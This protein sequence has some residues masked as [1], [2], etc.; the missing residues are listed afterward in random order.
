MPWL[1]VTY[2]RSVPQSRRIGSKMA[3]D[4]LLA[5]RDEARRARRLVLYAETR[6]HLRDALAELVPRHRIWVFG[7]LTKPGR[8][9][10]RSDVDLALADEPRSMSVGRLASELTERLG[11]P[12][13]LECS[14]TGAGSATAFFKTAN[15]GRPRAGGGQGAG[16]RSVARRPTSAGASN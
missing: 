7:S 12:V 14:S 16:P 13:D 8:F 4:A 6:H 9:N 5:R 1:P 10:D 15:S 2:S 3:A 11:R